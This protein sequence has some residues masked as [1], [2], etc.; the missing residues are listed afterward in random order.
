M[1]NDASSLS[2]QPETTDAIESVGGVTPDTA[3]GISVI[4]EI[5]EDVRSRSTAAHPGSTREI[6]EGDAGRMNE[7]QFRAA[8]PAGAGISPGRLIG[9]NPGGAGKYGK[10]GGENSSGSSKGSINGNSS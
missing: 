8:I 2:S 3:K 10:R 7:D 1:S 4:G 9:A 5:T 6:W